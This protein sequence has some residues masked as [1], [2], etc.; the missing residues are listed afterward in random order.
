M[1]DVHDLAEKRVTLQRALA[2]IGATNTYGR[3]KEDLIDIEMLRIET[4]RDLRI[5]DARIR[6][7]V[8][9]IE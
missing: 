2:A 3:T 9:E 6:A 1:I 5:I 8:E 7:Y 4:L